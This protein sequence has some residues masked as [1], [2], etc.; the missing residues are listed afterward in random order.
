MRAT[1]IQNTIFQFNTAKD[2]SV[3]SQ[4][5][6]SFDKNTNL[7]NHWLEEMNRLFSKSKSNKLLKNEG[8]N[9]SEKE[10]DFKSLL[11]INIITKESWNKITF[12][13]N[14]SEVTKILI[15]NTLTLKN[16][17]YEN[18]KQAFHLP[19]LRKENINLEGIFNSRFQ[20]YIMDKL[21]EDQD[22]Y[23]YYDNIF[24]DQCA[25]I[26]Q[27]IPQS[28]GQPF[29]NLL[30]NF[31]LL[32]E[33]IKN[34]NLTED[35]KKIRFY[36]N[37][38]FISNKETIEYIN[39]I[40][41]NFTLSKVFI[42]MLK[43]LHL[44]VNQFCK[45]TYFYI[46]KYKNNSHEF[47][48]EY[49]SRYTSYVNSCIEMNDKLENLNVLVNYLYEIIYN[50]FENKSP[51]FSVLRLMMKIWDQEVLSPLFSNNFPTIEKSIKSIFKNQIEETL[52]KKI[53][54][55][56]DN[57]YFH[58]KKEDYILTEFTQNMIDF[59]INEYSVF[60]LNLSEVRICGEDGY[61]NKIQNLFF[62]L[63]KNCL[64]ELK[65]EEIMKIVNI[66]IFSQ[67]IPSMKIQILS[68]FIREIQL[69][70]RFSFENNQYLIKKL[71]NESESIRGNDK[72]VKKEIDRRNITECLIR[73]DNFTYS[74]KN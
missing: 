38:T 62:D 46:L 6:K 67:I 9:Q 60:A 2:L 11:R 23:D 57:Q 4:V 65:I 42:Y 48:E 17:L 8:N 37:P 33:G 10:V 25:D 54:F 18:L 68:Y 41:S 70:S 34:N 58:F 52:S 3:I 56:H 40:S 30:I 27:L 15:E 7:P 72:F 14:Q 22:T 61:F 24:L 13:Q 74:F 64:N 49:N 36:E 51:K 16:D 45:F 31:N 63:T 21:Y 55:P 5:C 19:K 50:D 66:P 28:N 53:N 71:E 35:I 39:S 47:L 20:I 73:I 43:L 29:E 69:K 26:S 44:S 12:T 1:Y 59:M 32:F